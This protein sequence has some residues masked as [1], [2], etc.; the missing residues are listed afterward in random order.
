MSKPT[1]ATIE[2]LFILLAPFE[3][4]KYDPKR[5]EELNSA[6]KRKELLETEKIERAQIFGLKIVF[7]FFLCNFLSVYFLKI[8][9]KKDLPSVFKME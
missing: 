1:V 7:S 9:K 4:K 8:Q 2:D 3:D 6:F 5:I